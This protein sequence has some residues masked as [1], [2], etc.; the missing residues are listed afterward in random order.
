MNGTVPEAVPLVEK[1][2]DDD[3]KDCGGGDREHRPANTKQ[4]PADE[5]GHADGDGAR[6]RHRRYSAVNSA[7]RA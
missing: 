2:L 5:K 3:L 1:L 6:A 4:R 7:M